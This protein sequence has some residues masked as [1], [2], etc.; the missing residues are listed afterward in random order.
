M[1]LREL[2][3]AIETVEERQGQSIV[4]A[5]AHVAIKMILRGAYLVLE[6]A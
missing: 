6:I 1:I 3:L 5:V 2:V 4:D